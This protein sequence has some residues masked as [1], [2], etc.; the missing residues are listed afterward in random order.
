MVNV[1]AAMRGLVE[2]WLQFYLISMILCLCFSPLVEATQPNSLAS[3]VEAVSST[4]PAA[5]A[6]ATAAA[7]AAALAADRRRRDK[8]AGDSRD[9]KTIESYVS[10]F[11]NFYRWCRAH[12]RETLVPPE[13][14]NEKLRGPSIFASIDHA[15]FAAEEADITSCFISHQA[16][17]VDGTIASASKQQ[18]ARSAIVYYLKTCTP[19]R[20]LSA[21]ANVAIKAVMKGHLRHLV[22]AKEQGLVKARFVLSCSSVRC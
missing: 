12:G 4:V 11:R 9:A 8:D 19:A 13:T 6:A 2:V 7:S 22:K 14:P 1:C 21:A 10:V 18:A 17:N 3:L 20:L 5:T 15:K 16:T